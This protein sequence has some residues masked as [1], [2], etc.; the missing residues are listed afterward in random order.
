M[1][2]PTRGRPGRSLFL[3]ALSICILSACDDPTDLVGS[4]VKEIEVHLRNVYV[5]VFGPGNTIVPGYAHMWVVGQGEDFPCCVVTPGSSR[6]VKLMAKVGD[7]FTI[8][9]VNEGASSENFYAQ[10]ICEVT[11][12]PSPGYTGN[13]DRLYEVRQDNRADYHLTC[14]GDWRQSQLSSSSTGAL[15]R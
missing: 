11:G 1:R 8:R 10:A 5:G 12:L 6:F 14:V 4:D 2:N 13:G 9:S 7:R 15:P 3:S